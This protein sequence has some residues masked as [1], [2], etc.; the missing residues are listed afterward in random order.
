MGGTWY[1]TV[2]V[3]Y[4][5]TIYYRSATVCSGQVKTDG[6]RIMAD[7]RKEKAEADVG[8]GACCGSGS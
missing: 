5:I 3:D 2:S 7:Q 4:G 8:V 1:R 6:G